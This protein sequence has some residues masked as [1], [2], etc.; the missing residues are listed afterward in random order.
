MA[1]TITNQA[2][3]SYRYGDTNANALSNIAT[4]VVTQPLTAAKT[5][6]NP[7]YRAGDTLTFLLSLTNGGSTPLSNVSVADDL[8]TYTLGT[9]TL[10]PYTILPGARLFLGGADNGTLTPTVTPNGATFTIP[11]I[12]AGT[13]AQILYQV[14][15][16]GA[17][18]L[19]AGT[20]ITNTATV[21]AP[22]LTEAV[23]AAAPVTAAEYADVSVFKTMS[24]ATVTDGGT[25]TY[26][27]DITNRGNAEATDIVLTDAFNP[28]PTAITVTR[29]G[30]VL[31][32]TEYSFT[33]GT[34]TV[35][36]AAA[37]AG[38]TLPAATVA[39]DPATGAVTLTPSSTRITVTGTL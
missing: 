23:T 24:P 12:P 4:A 39:Q 6:L 26:T 16:T 19:A 5:A 35:P 15:L 11:S 1:Q 28:V 38:I 29:D 3:L 32:A 34:L 22:T 30:A 37:T 8:G 21:T 27:F 7:T 14:R 25:I 33:G 2:S 36:A 18:P 9:L 20:T 10:T 31:D 13:N 17:A